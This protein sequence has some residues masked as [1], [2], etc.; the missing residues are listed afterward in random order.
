MNKI[1]IKERASAKAFANITS[2]NIDIR[3]LK[4]ELKLY[5]SK[6][7]FITEEQNQRVLERLKT[8]RKIWSYIAK[9]IEIDE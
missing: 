6:Y 8:E 1:D 2:C 7:P 5:G 9:L 4:E 3:E